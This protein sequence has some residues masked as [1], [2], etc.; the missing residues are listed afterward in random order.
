MK[1]QVELENGAVKRNLRAGKIFLT[2][3][4]LLAPF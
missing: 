2:L 1:K 4:A 3:L